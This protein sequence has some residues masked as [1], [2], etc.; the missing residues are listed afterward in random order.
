[1]NDFQLERTG[2][3]VVISAPSG[4]GKSTIIRALLETDRTLTYSVS[5]TTRAPRDGEIHGQDYYFY[6]TEDF[7]KLVEQDMFYE[8]ALVHGNYYGTLKFEVDRKCRAGLDVILDLDVQGGLLLKSKMPE[9]TSVFVLPPSMDELEKRLRERGKDSEEVIHK[10]L[11]NARG[12]I[13]MADRYDFILVNQDLDETI[14]NVRNIIS[15]QRFAS[16]HIRI[17]D[18]KGNLMISATSEGMSR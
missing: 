11:V 14:A 13:I 9:C 12:E 2:L 8:Y 16:S 15:A 4:G 6:T 5:A 10:R 1:M 17:R 18:G 3:L 7:E